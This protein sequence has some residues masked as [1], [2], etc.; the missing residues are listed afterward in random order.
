MR[1]SLRWPRRRYRLERRISEPSPMSTL[2]SGADTDILEIVPEGSG[3]PVFYYPCAHEGLCRRLAEYASTP[4]DALL[5]TN[6]FGLL[7][8][9]ETQRA[10][11]IVSAIDDAKA[12]TAAHKAG[13][14][15]YLMRWAKA[16][17][18]AMRLLPVFDQKLPPH[19]HAE[20]DAEAEIAW[21]ASLARNPRFEVRL[22][23][24]DLYAAIFLRFFQ[25]VSDLLD[26]RRCER[27]G[28]EEWFAVGSGTG[29]RT[30]KRYCSDRCRDAESYRRKTTGGTP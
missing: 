2:M 5:F 30:T 14:A 18:E 23:P 27:A 21:Q 9:G 20:G 12:L 29:R 28:C 4:E 6:S 13:D 15:S 3:S 16:R 19:P 11:E 8:A 10:A 25:E 26:L 1:L 17:D 24:R 22:R 7:R